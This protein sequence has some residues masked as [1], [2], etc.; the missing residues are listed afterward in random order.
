M[1]NGNVRRISRGASAWANTAFIGSLVG[2]IAS[3]LIVVTSN[4]K[5]RAFKRSL[6]DA[7]VRTVEATA[8]A[9]G[10]HERAAEAIERAEAYPR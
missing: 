4:A 6:A 3:S 5:E 2:L 1:N 10:A 9:E 8:Q 7:A